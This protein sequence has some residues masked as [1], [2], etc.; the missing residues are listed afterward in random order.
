MRGLSE[1]P[2]SDYIIRYHQLYKSLLDTMILI[3]FTYD[4]GE[5]YRV[6]MEEPRK[7][8]GCDSVRIAM[9]KGD[10]WVIRYVNNLPGDL[11]GRSFTDEEFPHAALAMTTRKSLA[12]EDAFNDARTNTEMMKSLGIKS[13][14]VIPIIEN[15]VVTGMMFFDYSSRAA[16]F[17]DAEMDYAGRLTTGIAIALQNADQNKDFSEAKRLSKALDEIDAVLSSEQDYEAT[18][19][20]MLQLATDAIGAETAVVFSKEGG[21]RWTA[22]YEYKLPVSLIGQNFTNTEVKH[23]AIT[24]ETKRSFVSQ[25]VVNDP[26]IDQK[27]V[28]M[29]GIRSLLDLP[30]IVRGKVVGDLTFHYHS[31]AVPFTEQQIE[32]ARKL[33]T[34]ITLGLESQQIH[35]TVDK[36]VAERQKAEETSAEL[37]SEIAERKLVEKSLAKAKVAADGASRAKSQFLANM[38]HELRTPMTGVLGMLDLVLLGNLEADQRDFIETA[39]T[40]AR[41]LVRIL[42]DILDL[43]KI[44]MGKLSLIEKPFSIRNCVE[45]T[46]N[47][48]VSVAKN[49]GLEFNLTVADDV[50]ETLVGDQTRINQVLT[51]LAGNAVKFTVK[52]KVELRIA[53]GASAPGGKREVTFTVTDTGIGIPDDKKHLLFHIFSQV[54]ESH[55]RIYGGTGLGLIISKEIVERMGGTI[56]FTSEQGKGSIFSFTI[57][58][59]EP[60]QESCAQSAVQSHLVETILSSPGEERLILLT[61]DDPTISK[62]LGSMLK[63]SQYKVDFATDGLMAIEMW[64]KGEYDLVLMDIQ[65]PLL[66]GFE[67]TRAIRVKERD[68]GG[69]T[70]IVAMTAH[71]SKEDEQRCLDAGMDAFISKPIDFEK[72]LQVIGQNFKEKPSVGS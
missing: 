59:V 10:N 62:M 64:E 66:N 44:E 51:N 37:R 29:L 26:V 68:R 49:K 65:M 38:S 67:A 4:V 69:H 46:Y 30:L 22:R 19:K 52:G 42:N 58:L 12:I 15:D 27:F 31:D 23:T 1:S 13:V 63:L 6:L 14:L 36:T 7:V 45:N 40:S 60:R 3:N 18:M 53:A 8:L 61:E 56:T 35:D 47:I 20:K 17:A 28:K 43:T 48:L 5:I 34:A 2:D 39:Q 57:P 21:D 32:F 55:T 9:R 50:P 70:P 11:V 54:D 24:A 33:Q 16:A 25:D 72:A 71:A 41:S